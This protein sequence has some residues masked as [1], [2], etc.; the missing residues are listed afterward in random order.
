MYKSTQKNKKIRG[1]NIYLSPSPSSQ[2]R[3]IGCLARFC[4]LYTAIRRLLQHHTTTPPLTP[5]L[6]PPQLCVAP[7]TENNHTPPFSSL[8]EVKLQ[9]LS[10]WILNLCNCSSHVLCFY[11]QEDCQYVI[12]IDFGDVR[13]YKLWVWLDWMSKMQKSINWS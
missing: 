3:A 6:P 8:K 13:K 2:N 11:D 9:L 10:Y 7:N 5:V 4:R 12:F 1:P